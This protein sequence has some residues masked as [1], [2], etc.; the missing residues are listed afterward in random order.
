LSG[1]GVNQE[2]G[3]FVPIGGYTF[4]MEPPTPV[5]LT[6]F[7]FEEFVSFLFDHD[8][9]PASEK[10]DPW[11]FH[12]AV[13]F[14]AKK[15]CAYYV[16]L[17]RR[18]EFL[19]SRFTKPQ[20]EEGFWAIQGNPDCSVS[21]I[22]ED[23]DLPLSIRAEC[24]DSMVDLFKRLFATEPL[25]TSVQMWWDAL[26]YD[27]HC[28]NRNRER[29]GEDLELQDIFFQALAKVLAIDS[30]IC[31]G[32]ALHGLGH[33]HHPETEELIERYIEEH[34][35]LTQEQQTYARAAARFEVL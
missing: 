17:F 1:Y 22:I 32:A 13:E 2:L 20:L 12:V 23:S 19:L 7:S 24:I 31:K 25:D 3:R 4:F 11:Y 14:D 5:D 34:P 8:I 9:P 16:Q 30:W 18:P 6:N 26:C 33:L 35:S 21:R 28:G 27:W 10:Y 15:I 29:G